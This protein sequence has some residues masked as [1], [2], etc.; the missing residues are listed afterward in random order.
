MPSA[1]PSPRSVSRSL[2]RYIVV[3]DC[4]AIHSVF[5][6]STPRPAP[7][8]RP[9]SLS[10]AAALVLRS[11]VGPFS[12]SRGR[13]LRAARRLSASFLPL[14]RV[15]RSV[16]A[17]V[18]D[19]DVLL[20]LSPAARRVHVSRVVTRPSAAHGALL[21][22]R[23]HVGDARRSLC[24][25]RV[26]FPRGGGHSFLFQSHSFRSFRLFLLHPPPPTSALRLRGSLARSRRAAPAAGRA[27]R[28]S[29]LFHSCACEAETNH[30]S[31]VSRVAC[32][33]GGDS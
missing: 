24:F 7:P 18:A 19:V 25:P 21:G 28:H 8:D 30:I 9:R 5:F 1:R 32:L 11:D 3:H 22:A 13:C 16:H 10:P 23:G 14:R 31:L 4:C 26:S 15:W 17:T 2:P 12:A 6:V 20:T 29:F 27:P 33:C